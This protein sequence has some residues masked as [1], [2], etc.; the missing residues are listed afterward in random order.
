MRETET[1]IVYVLAEIKTGCA[2]CPE[3]CS[4]ISLR[5]TLLYLPWLISDLSNEI[6]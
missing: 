1:Y 5:K 2:S 6:K 3:T 4:L